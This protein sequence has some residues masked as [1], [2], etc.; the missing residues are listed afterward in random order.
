MLLFLKKWYKAG[1]SVILSVAVLISLFAMPSVY[2]KLKE[3]GN[4]AL[5]Y[6]NATNSSGSGGESV[7]SDEETSSVNDELPTFDDVPAES[8]PGGK[9]SDYVIVVSAKATKTQKNIAV[10]LQT[11]LNKISGGE[12]SIVT[13][14]Q[15]KHE[16]EIVIGDTVR[17]DKACKTDTDKLIYD[18]YQIKRVGN[19][20]H[21]GSNEE[22]GLLNG[23]YGFLEK[24]FGCRF[25]SD[26]CEK[27]L[28]TTRMNVPRSV[29][30]VDNPDFWGRAISANSASKTLSPKLR[31]NA[32][33]Y[34]N[35]F[36]EG[37]TYTQGFF[38]HTFGSLV[39]YEQ[40]KD[41][42]PEYFSMD[43]HG[44]RTAG[45]QLC[46]SNEDVL[47]L[48]VARAK[49]WLE[50]DPDSKIISISQNDG[51]NPCYCEKCTAINEEEGSQVGS[52][53]RFVNAVADEL[54]KDYPDVLVDT[55]AYSWGTVAPKVTKPRD[56]VQIRFCG[57]ND[58]K[59]ISEWKD[60]TKNIGYWGYQVN[61]HNFM[62]MKPNLYSYNEN[63]FSLQSEIKYLHDVGVTNIFEQANGSC[64]DPCFSEL[65]TYVM[66]K[67]M[68]DINADVEELINDFLENYYGDGWKSLRSYL[69]NYTAVATEYGP[70]Y[71]GAMVHDCFKYNTACMDFFRKSDEWWADAYAKATDEQQKRLDKS[72]IS[73]L[74]ARNSILYDAEYSKGDTETAIAY[75]KLNMK[76]E[77]LRKKYGVII[78]E[79]GHSSK[80]SSSTPPS[81]WIT[82][83]N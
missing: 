81:A 70:N 60:I 26:D 52:I 82:W 43:I 62:F 47:K 44:N 64:Y 6:T 61:Y 8:E 5:Q 11:Y 15:E 48:V 25:Y 53:L 45:E 32:N 69:K 39:D 51:Y 13:D 2:S 55:L 37:I 49:E 18:G 80:Y 76:L 16:F 72:Y 34:T 3:I 29:N 22:T 68:W 31:L 78:D 42:H 14:A 66:A 57:W 19:T 50:A 24:Y 63:Y 41:S 28:T 35:K 75:V 54:K 12:I 67:C 38:V 20:I 30:Y 46:T 56:N 36:S 1:I 40:Y 59:Q 9:I 73:F 21:I 79:Q 74:F 77:S 23:V 4:W 7:D 65:R 83:T 33:S 71:G 58:V 17:T 27:V 10:E